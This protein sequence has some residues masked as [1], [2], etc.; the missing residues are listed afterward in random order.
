MVTTMTWGSVDLNKTI[1]VLTNAVDNFVQFS[2]SKNPASSD[3]LL[4][5]DHIS[6]HTTQHTLY[7][8][9]NLTKEN[10]L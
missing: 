6:S 10:K 4:A 7:H 5:S 3:L 2:V 1:E 8:F 9:Q